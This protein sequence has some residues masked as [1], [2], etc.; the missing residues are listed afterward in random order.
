MGPSG[1]KFNP[2]AQHYIPFEVLLTSGADSFGISVE[3][4]GVIETGIGYNID[5]DNEMLI[6]YVPHF[7]KYYY[8]RR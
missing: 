5:F 8:E 2:C 3:T 1:T 6:A 7:S 4:G